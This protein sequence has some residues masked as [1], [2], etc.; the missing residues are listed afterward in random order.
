MAE[1]GREQDGPDLGVRIHALIEEL[2]PLCRS[3]T[4]DG[5]RETLRILSRVAP[6]Q[7]SEVASGT[8]VLD[9]TVPDEWN[10]REAWV[11]DA[12]GRRVVDFRESNLHVVGY[13]TPVRQRLSLAQLRPHLHA[14]PDRPACIPYRTSYYE[15][16][17]GF[18]LSQER[19]DAMPDGEYDVCIEATLEPGHLTY[20]EVVVPGRSEEEVLVTAHV[21]HP[22]LCDD[23][24]SG[25]AVSAFLAHALAGEP[26][27]RYTYRFLYAPGTIGAIAWL[28]RN[29][30]RAARIVH[31]VTLACLG[32]EKGFTYKRTLQGRAPVD[33]AFAHVL[34]RRGAPHEVID[35]VPYGYDERQFNSPGFRLPVGSLMRGRQGDFPEYHTSDDDLRLVSA[36]RLAEAWSLCREVFD[37]LEGN[38][39]FRSREPFGEPQLGR[40]GLYRATGGDKLPGMEMA[41]L[42]VLCLA[43]GQHSLLDVAERAA[44]PFDVVR[45]AADALERHAL[46]DEVRE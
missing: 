34:A 22:S 17:W 32:G 24:L 40:R 26:P 11:A 18:C 8:P 43:D 16:T 29:R 15:R 44:L 14:R 1:R 2:Y 41:M 5:V 6:L 13:S 21:C 3:L 46:L 36:P 9:W 45:A 23:N 35:Y 4:G 19:L 7:V 20:G 25:V 28:A 10:I 37:V 12:A 42:W 39:T 30:A 38:R 31:G 33:R 27:R